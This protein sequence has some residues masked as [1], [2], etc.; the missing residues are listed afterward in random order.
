M[1]VS[2]IG[3]CE[4]IYIGDIHF[5]WIGESHRI[6]SLTETNMSEGIALTDKM[7]NKWFEESM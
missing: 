4:N 5:Q 2:N 6:I 3:S 1:F 7:K